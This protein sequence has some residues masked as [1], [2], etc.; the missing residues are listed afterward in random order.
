LCSLSKNPP[1]CL[2]RGEKIIWRGAPQGEMFQS[3]QIFWGRGETQTYLGGEKFRRGGVFETHKYL[4]LFREGAESARGPRG[5]SLGGPGIYS[6]GF[7]PSPGPPGKTFEHPLPRAG[8]PEG[9]LFEAALEGYATTLN[10][11][12]NYNRG[13]KQFDF[14]LRPEGRL[15]GLTLTPYGY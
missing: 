6:C 2:A 10:V 12:D 9:P 1:P 11:N 15:I 4:T 5:H 14:T 3:P 8:P 13:K 7:E